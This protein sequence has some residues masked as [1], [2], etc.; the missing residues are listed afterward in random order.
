M[1]HPEWAI[2][3]LYQKKTGSFPY[4]MLSTVKSILEENKDEYI[5]V[6]PL[7]IEEKDYI[8]NP[9]LRPYQV[10]AVKALIDNNGGMLSAPCGC[11]VGNTLIE[12]PRDLKIYPEGIPIKN[13][14]GK[15]F[16]TYTYS[17]KQRR[18][19]LK[20]ASNIRVTGIGREVYKVVLRSGTHL[21]ATPEHKLL[22][23]SGGYKTI[24]ELKVG[25][26][27]RIFARKDDKISLMDE[28][29]TKVLEHHYV[30]EQLCGS[31]KEG[32][33]VHHI[34]GN[35]S[36]NNLNNLQLMWETDHARMHTLLSG[37]YG[38]SIWKN[39][40]HPKGFKGHKHSKEDLDKMFDGI[41]EK[42]VV[43]HHG[44]DRSYSTSRSFLE[45]LK[46]NAVKAFMVYCDNMT[47]EK[48]EVRYKAC[49]K[50]TG[51]RYGDK[52]VSIEYVGKED[53]YDMEVE[54]TH[55]FIANDIFIHNSGKTM[56]II[57]FIKHINKSTLVVVPTLDIKKQWEEQSPEYVDVKTYQSIKY[58]K[59]LVGYKLVVF[60]ES[61]HTASKIIYKIAQNCDDAITVGASATPYRE[62]GEDMKIEA[63][64]G[65][66]VYKIS[67][68]ELIE[69]GY[70]CDAQI[71]YIP[72]PKSEIEFLDYHEMYDKYIVNN[73]VR[74]D[75]IVNLAL[76][77]ES[78]LILVQKIEHGK[79]LYDK[80]Y[81]IISDK[82]CFINGQLPKKQRRKMFDDIRSKK[83]DVVI[84]SSVFDEGV[85]IPNFK[86]L[87]LAVGGK[88]SIK[89]VQ[90]VGRLL[91]PDKDKPYAV[92]YDFMD[93]QKFLCLHYKRRRIL[94][95]QD[96][97]VE[98]FDINQKKL[99]S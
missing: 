97:T 37:R 71:R 26:K 31:I 81:P 83:Y 43:S 74:N 63:A 22:L 66:I 50:G 73:K 35:H 33:C 24:S 1:V 40:K 64:I 8:P 5:L 36:N 30:Y 48:K 69:L 65:K 21:I 88:S 10:E 95:E 25:D 92:I 6:N 76:S 67:I 27:I 60:D 44:I 82:V 32:M 96:F 58:K 4:G 72:L 93:T 53:V 85:N 75:I 68:K 13:L 77:S 41:K 28:K 16:Y 98:E 89:V 42:K 15:T 94:L 38:K 70:L 46:T 47:E 34:D 80:L 59:Q 23:R 90:R 57:D 91:R 7:L 52:V 84:A 20:K 56:M 55:N 39:G 12:C 87:I 99:E 61:H 2:V 54:D 51:V 9:K 78:V 19:V 79:L 17:H 3:E 11:I 45:K 29:F 62:D 18:V 14:V 86:T 49:L